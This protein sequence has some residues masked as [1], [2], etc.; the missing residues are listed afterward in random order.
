[1]L[2]S[3]DYIQGMANV[4]AQ[5][6]N[7]LGAGTTLRMGLFLNDIT[8]SPE[9]DFADLDIATT[10]GL[11]AVACATGVATLVWKPDTGVYGFLLNEPAGGFNWV[12]TG[13]DDPAQVVYGAALWNT[14]GGDVLIASA[15]F[16]DPITINVVGQFIGLSAIPGYLAAPF[17]GDEGSITPDLG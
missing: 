11:A 2:F 15:R 9:T 8:P 7:T 12:A 4:L 5:E 17:I 14:D 3:N 1:M 10:N 16:T 13:V 6:P